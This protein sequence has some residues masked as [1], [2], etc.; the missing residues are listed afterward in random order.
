[1]MSTEEVVKFLKELLSREK[2]STTPNIAKVSIALGIVEDFYISGEDIPASIDSMVEDHYNVLQEKVRLDLGTQLNTREKVTCLAHGVWSNLQ[3][4]KKDIIH[5]Q[6]LYRFTKSLKEGKKTQLC[7]AG[8]T[9][10]VLSLAQCLAGAHTDLKDLRLVLTE[11]HCFLSL[12]G[13]STREDLAEVTTES[14]SARGLPPKE[15]SYSSSWLYAGGQPVVCSP[16]QALVA[17]VVSINY[18]IKSRKHVSDSLF[19]IQQELLEHL[20]ENS[21]PM[22][23]NAMTTLATMKE[24]S[25][26]HDVESSCS[27]LT[28]ALKQ[29]DTLWGPIRTLYTKSIEASVANEW[30]PSSSLATSYSYEY[31]LLQMCS[32]E[33]SSEHIVERMCDCLTRFMATICKGSKAFVKFR[34]SGNH[35]EELYKDID[36]IISKMKIMFPSAKNASQMNQSIL[37]DTLVRI[38][39]NLLILFSGKSLPAKWTTC[40]LACLQIFSKE[41]R[42]ETIFNLA[43][44][45]KVLTE[46]KPA[47][48]EYKKSVLLNML[49]GP[50]LEPGLLDDRQGRRK[51]RR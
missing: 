17:C 51:R 44:S 27:N 1:M 42:H 24:E 19:S 2:D 21:F 22:Y 20:F 39:D 32:K 25:Q 47:M 7:C 23:P 31:E 16:L 37:C 30:Y 14:R 3:N 43:L 49:E 15:S 36:D 29:F 48:I 45:S 33:E 13:S 34:Y 50:S 28:E 9:V 11:D 6:H 26:W 38:F 10:A 8:V 46:S 40:F 4:S 12:T 5:A 18:T 41:T 35:D